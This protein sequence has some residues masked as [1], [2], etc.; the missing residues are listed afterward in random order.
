MVLVTKGWIKGKVDAHPG[1]LPNKYAVYATAGPYTWNVPTSL[2]GGFV[3]AWLCGGGG[4]GPGYLATGTVQAGNGARI[5]AYIPV[6]A[7]GTLPLEVG[8][9]GNMGFN[10]S[11]NESGGGGG[12]A[13]KIDDVIA[14]GGGGV[15]GGTQGL[16]QSAPGG[17]GGTKATDVYTANGGAA[18]Y[19]V[20][21]NGGVGGVTGHGSGTDGTA[22]RGSKNIA[23]CAPPSEIIP[24]NAGNGATTAANG[25]SGFIIL[26][27]RE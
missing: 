24:A 16:L 3:F 18:G 25:K 2:L 4:A 9:G 10:G 12:G 21:T 17:A 20:A 19:G 22:T 23:M 13:S 11:N 15:G 14:G 7:G 1:L 6:T 5:S 27:W 26:M 8:G